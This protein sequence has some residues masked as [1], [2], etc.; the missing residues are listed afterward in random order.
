MTGG[1]AFVYDAAD[2]FPRHVNPDSVVW[3]RLDSNHWENHL[4]ALVAEHVRETQSRFAQQLLNDWAVES[5]RFWQVVPKEMLA[6]L[7]EPLS[8]RPVEVRA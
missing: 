4:K 7:A 6:R 1:M 2:A 5:G 8:D 3:Q